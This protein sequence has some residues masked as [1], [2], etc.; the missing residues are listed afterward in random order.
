MQQR[1]L[2]RL[3]WLSCVE[4]CS[5]LLLF[6]VA[7]PLKY[8]AGFPEAVTFTGAVHGGLFLAL[9]LMLGMGIRI[10]PYPSRVAARGIFAAVIPFGPFVFDRTLRTYE[11]S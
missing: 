9:C 1:Y 8:M 10:V 3:R 2:Q 7:M 11:Q 5:T 6:F 4:G